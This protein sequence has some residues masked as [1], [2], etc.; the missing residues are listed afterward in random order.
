MSQVRAE[1]PEERDQA[2]SLGP[3]AAATLRAWVESTLGQDGSTYELQR[4][5]DSDRSDMRIRMI[6]AGKNL[7]K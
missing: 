4:G 5:I 3:D 6:S 2:A 7:R 1:T